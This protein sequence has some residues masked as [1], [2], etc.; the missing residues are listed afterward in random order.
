ME[1]STRQQ[2]CGDILNIF[3]CEDQNLQWSIEYSYY[4]FPPPHKDV[5][6]A[7]GIN[8]VGCVPEV[9]DYKEM[10]VWCVYKYVPS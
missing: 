8:H 7:S 5:I 1:A 4:S 3:G 2:F 6:W 9:F 10:F